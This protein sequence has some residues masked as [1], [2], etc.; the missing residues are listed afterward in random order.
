MNMQEL[1]T[2]TY[3]T[4][5]LPPLRS[6]TAILFRRWKSMLI[7]G[8]VIA[9]MTVLAGV[10]KPEYEAQMK[11]LVESHRSDAMVSSSSVAPMQIGNNVTEEDLNSEV[12][13]LKAHDLLRKVALSAGLA[14]TSAD[15]GRPGDAKIAAAADRLSRALN[16]EAVRKTHVISVRYR[17][18]DPKQ[19]AAVLA[20][21]AAAY[22]EKHTG[23]HRPTGEFTFFDQ[24]ASRFR[25]ALE[26]AQQ[27]LAAFSADHNVVSAEV[28]RDT[29]VKQASDFDSKAKEA[30]AL[31]S[32]TESRI[33]TLR[34][35]L[36]SVEPRLT[37]AVRISE[38]PQ[39]MG[40]LKSTLLTLQ[41]KRNELLTKYDPSYPLVQEVDRQ[42]ADA[43][44]A[45]AAEERK[46]LRD[47][48]TDQ[49]PGYQLIVD[50]L[51]KAQ[52]E[53]TGLRARA[54]ASQAVAD[55]YRRSAH[56]RDQDS[57]AQQNLTRDAKTLEDAYLL[58]VHK[59]EEAGISDALDRRGI[60]NVAI[61]EQPEVP[62]APNRSPILSLV[63]ALGLVCAGSFSAAFVLEALNPT[64][65]T[66]DQLATYLGVPVLAA[67]P[68][69]RA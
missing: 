62:T 49:N 5:A 34:Q 18:R 44:A 42:I 16:V 39:L 29:A 30:V 12:E 47:V 3:L 63:F 32:E 67:L 31:A 60:V 19:A 27:K 41:L 9:L 65:R 7:V 53:S 4:H 50:E 46:P 22:V 59:S 51:A 48:T 35:E 52:A 1:E 25:Q 26:Q 54:S 69:S 14:G 61:A 64:F 36:G 68:K 8:A 43:N 38:N 55:E 37:T 28:E 10:W 33:R 2:G 17:S 45:I 20:T 66:P 13:L 23:V 40:Q 58:Y 56:L 11:I 6:G 21:L 57:I 24:E 15:G